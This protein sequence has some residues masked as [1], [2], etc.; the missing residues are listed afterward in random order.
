MLS[1]ETIRRRVELLIPKSI[2]DYNSDKFIQ[3][4]LLARVTP[5]SSGEGETDLITWE[6]IQQELQTQLQGKISVSE[7]A[8]PG[9]VAT[10]DSN[11]TIPINQLP[12]SILNQLAYKGLWNA[13]TNNPTL[14]STPSTAG[15]FY[16]VSEEGSFLGIT[17]LVGDWIISNG[18]I[19]ER[20]PISGSVVNSFEGRTGPVTAKKSDYEDF[21]PKLDEVYENP[22]WI[23][24][25]DW[26]KLIN[27]PTTFEPSS[28]THPW[29][30]I[31]D[32][33]TTFT[34]SSHTHPWSEI[35]SIPAFATRWPT[36]NEVTNKPTTFTP[37]SHTHPWSQ[38]T[39]TIG[40]I[41]GAGASS[42]NH[43]S[44][45]VSGS[46]G[47]YSGI[48]F[49]DANAVFMV[50][51]SDTLSGVYVNNN[52]WKWYF[53]GNGIL[54]VGTV[55]WARLSDV[56]S[57]FAPSSHNLNSH[58]DVSTSSNTNGQLL[59]WNGS[60]WANWTPNFLTAFTETDPTVPAHVKAI[61]TTNISNW[62]TAFGWGN[63]ASA[64]YAVSG[65]GGS[66]VRTNT[67][68]DG[69][70]VLQI[71]NRSVVPQSTGDANDMVGSFGTARSGN[72]LLNRPENFVTILN[73]PEANTS[74]FQFAATYSSANRLWFR[75]LKDNGG[76]WK[77][78]EQI[79]HSGNLRSN[80]Q[81][82][83]RYLQ[84]NQTIALSGDVTGSG[85]TSIQSAIANNAVT[86]A[87]ISNANV[88]YAKI[89][90]V[91]ANR[92]LGR[93]SSNGTVQELSAAQVR[94]LIGAE[95]VNAG[96][97]KYIH[98]QSTF[99]KINSST[100]WIQNNSYQLLF[101]R[102]IRNGNVEAGSM[103][104]I[105]ISV[106]NT[107]NVN[108]KLGILRLTFIKADNSQQQR[109]LEIYSNGTGFMSGKF[110][111]MMY[112]YPIF[113]DNTPDFQVHGNAMV[114]MGA[115]S[116]TIGSFQSEESPFTNAGNTNNTFTLQIH[117]SSAV[118]GNNNYGGNTAILGEI[119]YGAV[120][121]SIFN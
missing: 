58:S 46:K 80:S 69:R 85:T 45:S 4:I 75:S 88:T 52:T 77:P 72:T 38:I 71:G 104:N 20:V 33:P 79:W 50:R 90:N 12:E 49:P 9:G 14:T 99:I 107:T 102:V 26:S 110:N 3:A 51:N 116:N 82:D 13:D 61:T 66:S 106:I 28:H 115:Q 89:Q 101:S 64:G 103:I 16:I 60:V 112:R 93:L 118:N 73:I 37:S 47:G 67:Q 1:N 6:M 120:N 62:N 65:T 18:D 59:R 97:K 40:N 15:D 74:D 81:N 24:T 17:F 53:N 34:P 10:L 25:L 109:F 54:T 7:K 23:K 78:W 11:G 108:N 96:N 29:S 31:T 76:T 36:W 98:L 43:G 100:D 21:Y 86:T 5:T 57:T 35:T 63:H 70:Y 39:G 119:N 41:P 68:L 22:T 42:H 32:K 111:I 56:P 83:E 2:K 48:A 27:K 105:N 55:P 87:K 113:Q 95:E 91:T 117:Y 44:V 19:W 84:G 30:Q 8:E 94:T 92:L 121:G 114:S